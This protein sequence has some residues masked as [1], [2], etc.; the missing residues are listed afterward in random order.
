[1][2]STSQLTRSTRLGLAHRNELRKFRN[3]V[4]IPS[5]VLLCSS[6]IDPLLPGQPGRQ[7][8]P[9]ATAHYLDRSSGLMRDGKHAQAVKPSIGP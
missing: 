6:R 3:P 9:F 1:M 4:Q 8:R 5:M 7:G 2:I